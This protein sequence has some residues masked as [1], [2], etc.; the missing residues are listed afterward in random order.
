M[1]IAVISNVSIG[2][3]P[4]YPYE[5]YLLSKDNNLTVIFHP[6]VK[7]G[8]NKSIIKEANSIINQYDYKRPIRTHNYILQFILS[9]WWIIK[10][11]KKFDII[12]GMGNLNALSALVLKMF[13][14]TNSVIF[15][16]VDYSLNRFDNKILNYV[17]HLIDRTAINNANYILSVSERIVKVREVQGI[18]IGKNL[19]QPNGVHIHKIKK[20]SG[21]V[22][23][24]KDFYRMIF[25][26]HITKSK[27]L[28]LI[29]ESI[30]NDRK[31]YFRPLIL[32]IYGDGPHLPILKNKVNKYGLSELVTF[33]GDVSNNF[34]L[35]NLHKYDIGIA[36]YTTDDDFNKYC[37][38]VKV[39]EYMAADLP[40]IISDVPSVASFISNNHIG[41]LVDNSSASISEALRILSSKNVVHTMREN[42][43]TLQLKLDWEYIFEKNYKIYGYEQK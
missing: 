2:Y 17:Y 21:P 37:D 19:L 6:L 42:Y 41:I 13:N 31:T 39:K 12:V 11:K 25:T 9:I 14:K 23:I 43:R 40:I 38:P 36:T 29:I 5:K 28:D 24:D 4:T 10:Q 34:I 18:P 20:T 33:K 27:G 22:K 26:G 32:D 15:Y 8:I 7:S 3:A 1:N 35:D 16:T 30:K